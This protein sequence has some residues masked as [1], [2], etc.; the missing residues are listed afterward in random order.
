MNIN[1]YNPQRVEKV[2]KAVSTLNT[3]DLHKETGLKRLKYKLD[4]TF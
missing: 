1:T 2:E 3:A 4:D